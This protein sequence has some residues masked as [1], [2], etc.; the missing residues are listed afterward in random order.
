MNYYSVHQL[1]QRMSERGDTR[2]LG[3]RQMQIFRA[4]KAGEFPGAVKLNEGVTSPWLIPVIEAEA[5]LAT[6]KR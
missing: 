2:S 6:P 5:W 1:A 4:I 3:A